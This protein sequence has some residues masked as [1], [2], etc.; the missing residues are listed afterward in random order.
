MDKDIKEKWVKALRSGEYK[1]TRHVL[2]DD[3]GHCG[4]GVLCAVQGIADRQIRGMQFWSDKPEHW[5]DED[6]TKELA[7]MNDT[8]SSFAEIADYIEANL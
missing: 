5:P 8:G 1:Q 7:D 4:L 3:D 6:Q 2:R